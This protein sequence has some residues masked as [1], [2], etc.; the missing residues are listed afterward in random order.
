LEKRGKRSDVSTIE[1]GKGKE[2]GRKRLPI[3]DVLREGRSKPKKKG[4]KANKKKKGGT[5][6][7]S[8]E[9][10]DITSLHIL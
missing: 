10:F 1:R 5:R 2:G 8:S 6:F 3:L 4:G 7:V 9:E